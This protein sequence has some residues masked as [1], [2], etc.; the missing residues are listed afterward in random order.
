MKSWSLK[1]TA[2]CAKCPWRVGVDPHD[3]P[4]GYSLD[5]HVELAVTIAAPAALPDASAPLHVMACHETED[6][7][8]IGWLHHQLGRGN[9]IALRLRMRSCTNSGALRLRGGQHETFEATLPREAAPLSPVDD[10]TPCSR[11]RR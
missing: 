6:A 4:N 11:L 7:H 1:R 5:K 2:Q 8:C 9:N 3:I 10:A